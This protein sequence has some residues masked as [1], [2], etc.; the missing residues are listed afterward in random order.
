MNVFTGSHRR[1]HRRAPVGRCMDSHFL[2]CF[3]A[4]LPHFQ[5]RPWDHLEVS[6][7]FYQL[8]KKPTPNQ[9]VSLCSYLVRFLNLKSDFFQAEKLAWAGHISHNLLGT[10][11]FNFEM[12]GVVKGMT[13][14]VFP[15]L[16][17]QSSELHEQ[18]AVAPRSS[19]AQTSLLECSLV[20]KQH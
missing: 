19:V 8:P 11:F 10:W 20:S 16:N 15:S 5:A 14:Q 18:P 2:I 6:N 13:Y 17:R 9:K 7:G 4:A 12:R 3:L 1:R